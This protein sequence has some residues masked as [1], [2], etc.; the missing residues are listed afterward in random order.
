MRTDS[1]PCHSTTRSNNQDSLKQINL[2][3]HTITHMNRIITILITL[4]IC[5]GAAAHGNEADR[6]GAAPAKPD[7]EAWMKEMQQYKSDMMVRRL[8]LSEEQKTKFVPLQKKMDAEIRAVNEDARKLAQEVRKKGEAATDL[9]RE[10]AAEAQFEVKGKEARI[11]MKYYREF[12]KF[13]SPAQLLKY[14]S[15]ERDYMRS[16]M[17][18]HREGKKNKR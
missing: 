15:V 7:R 3:R 18:T 13:L 10:K 9:E 8:E 14:K 4:T 2:F 17:K 16:L 12:R 6:K 11:E 5:L 1:P